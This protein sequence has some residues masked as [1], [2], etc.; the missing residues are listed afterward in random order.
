M[1]SRTPRRLDGS[2]GDPTCGVRYGGRCFSVASGLPL[3]AGLTHPRRMLALVPAAARRPQRVVALVAL[4]LRTPSA[5]VFL[6]ESLTGQALRAYL[7]ERSLGL[8]PKNRLCRGVLVLPQDRSEYLRGR[9]RQALRTNLRRAA[10]AGIRCEVVHERLRTFD[11]ALEIFADR[12]PDATLT[13]AEATS[14]RSLLTRQEMT[15]LAAHDRLGRPLAV[16]A[17]L[18]D[19]MVCLLQWSISSSHEARWALHDHLVDVL[20]ARGARYLV[21]SGGGAFGALGL[22]ASLQHYQR[23]LG[24]E[25]RHLSP[26]PAGAMT[27][28]RRLLV[29]LV[30]S[31]AAVV[32]AALLLIPSAAVSAIVNRAPQALAGR[33]YAARDLPCSRGVDE[34]FGTA[35]G[36]SASTLSLVGREPARRWCSARRTGAGNTRGPRWGGGSRRSDRALR[37]DA[38][39]AGRQLCDAS[40][41]FRGCGE[42][43]FPW[44]R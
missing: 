19:D 6:S 20:I 35:S 13:A 2:A 26:A 16:A 3:N 9:H 18:I 4:L 23:L 28:K 14:W 12:R 39:P 33:P 29:A 42:A 38:R 7:D 11:E 40:A 5:C 31:V 1:I 24:Y 43:S 34:H 15:L 22:G 8:F 32:S 44:V 25:L 21:A 37:A 30:A 27:R 36:N 17:V 10:A 41:V